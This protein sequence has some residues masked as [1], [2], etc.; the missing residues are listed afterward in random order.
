M[1]GAKGLRILGCV[2]AQGLKPSGEVS[3]QYSGLLFRGLNETYEERRCIYYY[4]PDSP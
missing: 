1:L 2:M 4:I 3:S